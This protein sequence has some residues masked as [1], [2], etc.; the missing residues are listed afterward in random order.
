MDYHNPE[1]LLRFSAALASRSSLNEVLA[2][3]LPMIAAALNVEATSVG[4]IGV[5]GD[6]LVLLLKYARVDGLDHEQP[7]AFYS[8][9]DF[10]TAATVI[11][12]ARPIVVHL[13]SDGLSQRDVA[14]LKVWN[15]QSALLVPLVAGD[16]VT[17]LLSCEMSSSRREFS[18]A[19]K[20]IAM[21]FANQLGVVL[22]RAHLYEEEHNRR[23]AL[24]SLVAI[25]H[26]L[27]T[28][29]DINTVLDTVIEQTI[30]VFDVAAA[31]VWLWDD[32]HSEL[33]IRANKGLSNHY[34]THQRLPHKRVDAMRRKEDSNAPFIIDDLQEMSL[35]GRKLVEQEGLRT[36]LIAPLVNDQQQLIGAL[37]VASKDQHRTFSAAEMG[38]VAAFAR[39]ATIAIE[40]GQLFLQVQRHSNT[41]LSLLTVSRAVSSELD[42]KACL[43]VVAS[44]AMRL[45]RADN[46]T[47]FM[48][49][50]E[51]QPLRP[52]VSIGPH[53][54]AMLAA[55]APLED[56]LPDRVYTSGQ[57]QFINDIDE[58]SFVP[59]TNHTPPASMVAVPLLGAGNPNGVVLLARFDKDAPFSNHD[60]EMLTG[61]SNQVAM[62][63]QNA[64][65]YE[66][67]G[68]RLAEEETLNS[69]LQA[70]QSVGASVAGSLTL[71]DLLSTV[72]T[73]VRTIIDA[74]EVPFFVLLD[75]SER[76]SFYILGEDKALVEQ[77]AEAT[78]F[79]AKEF[80]V[81][82]DSLP[83]TFQEAMSSG[84][85]YITQSVLD[86]ASTAVSADVIA[87][88]ETMLA[89]NGAQTVVVI[90]LVSKGRMLGAMLL[91]AHKP[92]INHEELYML[93]SFAEQ[94]ATAIDNAQLFEETVRR[95]SELT[96]L[97]QVALAAASSTG[98]DDLLIRV[99]DVV[100]TLLYRDLFSFSLIDRE[101]G[102]VVRVQTPHGLPE[103]WKS[104]ET[105]L[106]QGVIG[107]VAETGNL[108][109][110]DDVS[111]EP[112]YV[113]SG[114][115]TRS[116][117][118][119]PLKIGGKVVGVINVES[120]KIGAFNLD[121]ARFLEVLAEQLSGAI[122][123]VGLYDSL[124]E[125]AAQVERALEE[126]R[127]AD[128]LKTRIIQNVSHELRTPLTYITSYV[129]LLLL[130]KH[131]LNEQQKEMLDIVAN[132]ADG[133][134]HLIE[135]FVTL[136][137][138]DATLLRRKEI[139]VEHLVDEAL[140]SCRVLAK[141]QGTELV[142]DVKGDLP[143]LDIDPFRVRQVF[144]NLLANAI[145][146][147][148]D[149]GA[150]KVK[151]RFNGDQMLV[152][153]S[154]SGIG[155][156]QEQQER[157]FERFYQVDGGA[158]R[159]FGGAGLGLSICHQIVT[160]HGGTMSVESDGIPG[161]G[162]TFSF[163][164]PT[165]KQAASQ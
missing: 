45:V 106:G 51:N 157:I 73:A 68:T 84:W 141:Q 14:M 132:K 56:S 93:V 149:G 101:R 26:T 90:P 108:M 80:R 113:D 69:Q 131:L 8:L 111:Q 83:T 22:E 23:T 30:R 16:R 135:D 52:V 25:T 5:G 89:E 118:A 102:K 139:P 94:A 147:S 74:A 47:I 154:D 40:R 136:Q 15:L 155:I 103:E 55:S 31:A 160:A 97:R 33:I 163:T 117:M 62:A 49:D 20:R 7:G 13:D 36:T 99:A 41:S 109:I 60:V 145:K 66:V 122:E 121:D 21:T 76:F 65:L 79:D 144:D 100:S 3:A 159:R 34:V 19:E 104:Y 75:A 86:L 81:R 85:P 165:V 116:E 126:V 88:L 50:A 142:H 78:G 143:L 153:V 2:V 38:L 39:Q 35:S 123:R 151:A 164:L 127:E 133:L 10:P 24:E 82:L 67:L 110:V 44:E 46:S 12:E 134:V 53:A 9:A 158:T 137:T 42:L 98:L 70:L 4:E 112:L 96:I 130:D 150:I 63:V 32:N 61:F 59:L 105:T 129:D 95:V 6:D 29:L 120:D 138:I 148:P 92:Q 72:R 115:G 119:V 17:G 57:G 43:S 28:T 146:F 77:L 18:P 156:S 48:L 64:R 114:V 125:H 54:D 161:Q 107:Q 124:N 58:H 37:T 87:G 71:D 27:G 1:V 11:A 140:D 91:P 162:S 152:S 128:N